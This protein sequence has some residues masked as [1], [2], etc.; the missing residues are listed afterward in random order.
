MTPLTLE[1]FTAKNHT[2]PFDLLIVGGGITGAALAYEAASRGYTAALVEKGD[3]SA[4]TSAATGKLIHGGLRYLKQLDIGLVRESLRERRILSNIAPNLVYPFPIVLPDTGLVEKA[5]LTAYDL[6]SFDRNR[7]WDRS[8]QIPGFKVMTN[9]DARASAPAGGRPPKGTCIRYYDCLCLSPERL[10]LAFIKSAVAHGAFVANYVRADHLLIHNNRVCGSQVTDTISGQTLEIQAKVTVNAAGPWT[11]SLLN[12][13]AQTRTPMPPMR[14]EGIYL[15]TRKITDQMFLVVGDHGHFS[16]APWRNHSL[17]GPTETPYYGHPDDWHITGKA[18][19][20]FLGVINR[21]AGLREKLTPRDVLFAYGGLRPLT[22]VTANDSYNASRR[23]ELHD[24]EKEGISG[25]ITAAG[26]KYTTSRNFA[27]KIF[28][29]VAEKAGKK[30]G[31]CVS[32][33]TP[34]YGCALPDIE[35][36]IAQAQRKTCSRQT[37]SL[38]PATVGPATIDYLVRHYGTEYEAVLNLTARSDEEKDLTTCVTPDKE[39]MAQVL[40]AVR[41]EMAQQLTDIFFRRTG[42]GWLGCPAR[43]V[44]EQAADIAAK[45]L[46]WSKE[47]R[48]KQI[49][50]VYQSYVYP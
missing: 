26:G 12:K 13:T 30:P 19:D 10:T 35:T 27:E 39:I 22:E 42:M 1:R 14:S 8:K 40:F 24:H 33:G 41:H 21:A 44:I 11:Q 9:A 46:N 15:V 47:E 32:A 25:L 36:Q 49:R 48:K 50:A 17:I 16:F 34:L 20:N 6:L 43:S 29:A 45:Q 23:S 28:A 2:G 38:T 5:G 3:F 18:I 7:V 37:N 4:A 31:P